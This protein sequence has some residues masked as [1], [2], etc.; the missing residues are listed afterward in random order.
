V[1]AAVRCRSRWRA[2]D[3]AE[4][5]E[6]AMVLPLMLLIVFGVIDF[7]LLFQR[8]H[9]I[10]N[11]AREGARVAVLPGYLDADVE[12]RVAQFLTAGGLTEPAVT[13]V[14]PPETITV[15]TQCI[16]VRPVSVEYPYSYSAVGNIAA[17]FG[18]TGFSTT[19]LRATATMRNEIA[20]G[21]CP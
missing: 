1:L 10:T 12:A 6:F 8:Y 19:G 3:G 14:L 13:T 21:S 17:L 18:G 7:G 2:E 9:V 5:I 20:A 4:L 11:A 15:G 16:E